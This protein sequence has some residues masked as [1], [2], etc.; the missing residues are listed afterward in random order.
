VDLPASAALRVLDADYD[1]QAGETV[2]ERDA[3]LE[4]VNGPLKLG[5]GTL[6]LGGR[7]DGTVQ[8]IPSPGSSGYLN[9]HSDQFP[10]GEIRGQLRFGPGPSVGGQSFIA[11]NLGGRAG[12]QEYDSLNV[13]D[14]ALL[15][16]NLV[17]DLVNGFENSI[18]STDVFT[19]LTAE[20]LSGAFENVIKR[21]AARRR[22]RTGDVCG[23]LRAGQP[24]RSG[25]RRAQRLP[26]H[27]RADGA[28]DSVRLRRARRAQAA[29]PV[30]I[31][32][33]LSSPPRR[34]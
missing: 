22:G 26:F 28:Y 9:L 13:T 25:Q 6:K 15:G 11:V 16:G 7:I 3:T 20:S 34:P 10:G 5:G 1:Q 31:T 2:I 23:G 18:L 17:V 14:D 4:I 8:V 27:P 21:R 33:A 19:V 12:G 29:R 24:V 30:L 32:T